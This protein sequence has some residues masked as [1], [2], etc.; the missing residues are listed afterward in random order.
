MAPHE[1]A[2]ISI[3]L[4]KLLDGLLLFTVHLLCQL[5]MA[6]QNPRDGYE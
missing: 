2:L 4:Y 3:L 6:F 5:P 1:T